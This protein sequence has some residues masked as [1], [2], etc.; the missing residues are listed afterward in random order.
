MK[1]LTEGNI[2]KNFIK[3]SI[4][5]IMSN[6]LANAYSIADTIIVGRYL[7]EHGLAALGST[8]SFVTVISSLIWGLGSGIAIYI[9]SVFGTKDYKKCVNSVKTNLIIISIFAFLVSMLAIVFYKPVFHVLAVNSE[10]WHDS[11]VYYAIYMAGFVSLAFNWSSVYT[12]N[13]MGNSSFAFKISLM[14]CVGNILGNIIFVATFDWG[15]AGA[16]IASVLMTFSGTICYIL[17][18]KREFKKL[19]VAKE[20]IIFEKK[21]II[22]AWKMGIPSMLQQMAMY[23]SSVG[24]QPAVN[25]LGNSAI[26]AY[27]VCLRIYSVMSS[28]FQNFSK[29]FSNYCAQCIGGKKVNMISMGMKISIKQ[30]F[31]FTIPVMLVLYI[32]P[33]QIAD[34]FYGDGGGE[35]THYV[36]RYIML[37]VPFVLCQVINNMFHNFYRGVLMPKIALYT[38]LVYSVVRVVS[39]YALVPFFKMDGI[40]FGFIIPWFVEMVVCIVIYLSNK[41]KNDWYKALERIN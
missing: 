41:W 12:L 9:A 13:S 22:K 5:L 19:G 32:F 10:I 8:A 1:N 36:V 15:V 7:G 30:S 38:T 6:F 20:K 29:G 18:F 33:Q 21:E 24:V 25:I 40:F 3:F 34:L 26:A 35:G 23:F 16:A 2:S 4:P 11:F 39:T 28:V 27:S 31:A 37:C 17:K 14:T